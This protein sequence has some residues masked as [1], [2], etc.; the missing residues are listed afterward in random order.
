M[1]F[2]SV[3]LNLISLGSYRAKSENLRCVTF[4]PEPVFRHGKN[5]NLLVI[6]LKKTIKEPQEALDVHFYFKSP[7]NLKISAIIW[8]GKTA[9]PI[10]CELEVIQI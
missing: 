5:P 9:R 10:G 7:R 2:S 1:D 6:F 8:D 3:V 4:S